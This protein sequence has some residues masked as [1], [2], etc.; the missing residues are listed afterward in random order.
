MA[1][2]LERAREALHEASDDAPSQIHEQLD[3]ID[4]GLAELI[5]GD[6]TE[7]A[8]P[9][10]DRIEELEE[11]LAGLETETEGATREH[12]RDARDHLHDYRRDRD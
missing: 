11:K 3:S 8:D 7:S 4:E 10:A 1:T 2:T 5:E 9:H 12:I 6:S